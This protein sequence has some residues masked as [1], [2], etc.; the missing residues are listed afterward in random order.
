MD[1]FGKEWTEIYVKKIND[2]VAYKENGKGWVNPIRFISVKGLEKKAVWLD[3]K[4]GFCERSLSDE[5]ALAASSF[6]EIQA[7]SRA[8]EHL[9]ETKGDPLVALITGKL[10]LT[11]G[12][13]FTLSRYTASA[14]DLV[15]IAA[16]VQISE[17]IE[18]TEL[19]NTEN[20]NHETVQNTQKNASLSTMK[21]RLNTDSFPYRLYEKAKVLGIWNPS[22]INFEQDE[23]DWNVCNDAEKEL[24]LHLTSL[25]QSGEE[26]VTN[27]IVPLLLAVSGEKRIEEELF[28]TTFLFEEAKHTD[29]FNR[30]LTQVVKTPAD[31]LDCFKGPNY[32]Q[33]F[34][35]ELNDAMRILLTEPS[36]ENQLR[37]SVTYNMVV[38]GSLAETGYHAYFKMLEDHN[39]MPGIRKGISLL[40]QDE[41]RHIAYGIYLI[42][43]ILIEKPE[44]KPIFDEQMS[45]CME[46]VVG[47]IHEIFG[48]YE[49]M[50]FGLKA[51]D[52]IEYATD[53]FQ[54]RYDRI[55][56]SLEKKTPFAE[57]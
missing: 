21:R 24:I 53:Q 32:R 28:L 38:E 35:V 1:L 40:K 47:V 50:A 39:L 34:D 19:P 16:S 56:K 4:N 3:L 10:K 46:L 27:E 22:D 6:Y 29:F 20:A 45:R 48:R 30:L 57:M 12:S 2:D 33:L 13:L 49:I 42:S 43:R 51:E 17:K 52:F 54:K 9:L 7:E 14:K 37:A 23:K 25:F 15:R 8:W 18:E 44:L 41:S 36:A 31:D 26:S 11:K 55:M 5:D